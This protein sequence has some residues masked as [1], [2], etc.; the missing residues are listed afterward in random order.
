MAAESLGG[1]P[2]PEPCVRGCAPWPGVPLGRGSRPR[3]IGVGRVWSR[4]GWEVPGAGAASAGSDS[5]GQ[6][7]DQSVELRNL[8]PHAGKSSK[9]CGV[10]HVL[11][12]ALR[13]AVG[14][15]QGTP[16]LFS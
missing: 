4:A 11:R 12:L 15:P 10:H 13:V 8:Q 5:P 1:L 3:R 7:C 2:A 6:A 14:A 16:L 9:T